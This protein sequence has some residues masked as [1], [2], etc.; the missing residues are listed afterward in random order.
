MSRSVLYALLLIIGLAASPAWAQ[1]T[2]GGGGS[3]TSLSVEEEDGAPAVS[4]VATL[5]FPNGSVTDNGGGSVSVSA[6]GAGAPTTA[7]YIVQTA[8]GSL[9]N[10]QALGALATGIVKNT[11]TTGVLS[12]ATPG[13]DYV[14]PAGNVATATAL[15]AN[16]ANCSAGQAPLGVNASGAAETCTDYQEEPGSNGL[17]AKT[18]ANTSAARTI[19]GTA[20]Q[21]AVSNGDGVSGN[22]TLSIP[23]NPVFP[24]TASA[25]GFTATGASSGIVQMNG[26]TTGAFKLTTPDATGQTVT[27]QP[28]AQTSGAATFT[29]QDAAGVNQ[30]I[31]TIAQAQTFTNKTLDTEAAGNAITIPMYWDLDLVGV[32]GGTASH[33]WNDDPLSTACTPLAVTGTNRTTGVCTFPDSD[34]DYGR[35]L[36]RY[37]PDGWGGSF[38]A[39]IW[40]KTT[41]TGNARFQIQTKC[42]ADDEADDAA[43]NTAS[44]VTAAAGTSARPNKQTIT[45][46]TTTGCAAGELMR[47]R[48]YRNRTEASDTLNAALDVEK[49]VFKGRVTH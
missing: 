7:T 22:P 21:I 37:L 48:F 31:A 26:V 5:K 9:S 43:M 27:L 4:G 17:V 18:A 24:G 10:E 38:D 39:E 30:T 15:A 36:S 40:W 19:T 11:T 41:G 35:Q 29:L 6:G 32:S 33:I 14:A 45:G 2:S 1:N 25:T 3:G 28:A 49:V 46:I 13:T 34:G 47:I 12:I 42:Y 23:T 20:N 8:D 16:G 44:V